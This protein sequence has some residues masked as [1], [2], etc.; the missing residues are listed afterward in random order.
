MIWPLHST[1]NDTAERLRALPL[2]SLIV[3][4]AN[5]AFQGKNEGS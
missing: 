3:Q 4:I 1:N 2:Y 5:P